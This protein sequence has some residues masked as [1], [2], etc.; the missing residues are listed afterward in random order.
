[1]SFGQDLEGELYVVN[2]GDRIAKL[3]RRSTVSAEAPAPAP[4]A[5]ARL[6]LTGA[7]PVRGRTTFRMEGDGPARL[8]VYDALGRE[9]AV[10]FEGALRPAVPATVTFDA[11]G[12]PAGAYFA[13]LDTEAGTRTLPLTVVRCRR[14]AAPPA[15]EEDA[16]RHRH[17]ERLDAAPRGRPG[18]ADPHPSIQP[19][20]GGLR[21]PVRLAAQDEHALGCGR[22]GGGGLAVEVGAPDGQAAPAEDAQRFTEVVGADEAE[23][24]QPAHRAAD[25]L[26]ALE[27]GRARPG[28]H[29]VEAEPRG[30]ADERAYVAGV[31]HAVEHEHRAGVLQPLRRLGNDGVS[32]GDDPLVVL[33][34]GEARE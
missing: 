28:E 32:D 10:L 3:V 6:Q 20:G 4:A 17:V 1:Y 31:L 7:N 34:V 33:H 24:P 11:R 9:V 2:H 12:L 5:L 21:E 16:P 13:R 15:V 22:P 18:R 27:V 8:V 25:D 23:V 19:R 26:R 14:S 30:G 29:G